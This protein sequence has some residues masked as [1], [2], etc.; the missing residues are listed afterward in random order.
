[1]HYSERLVKELLHTPR[2]K[3]RTLIE[4]RVIEACSIVTCSYCGHVTDCAGMSVD[5]RNAALL[6]HIVQCEKRPEMKML[7]ICF[8]AAEAVEKFLY[9]PNLEDLRFS[10]ETMNHWKDLCEK[11]ADLAEALSGLKIEE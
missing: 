11:M 7:K 4:Q 1:M 3:W 6:K 8:A 9:A 2:R 5:A 10:P